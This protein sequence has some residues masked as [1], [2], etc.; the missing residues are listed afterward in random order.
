MAAGTIITV[1]SNI[2]WGQVVDNAPKVADGASKLW[3]AVVNRKKSRADSDSSDGG[4]TTAASSERE[5]LLQRVATLEENV[6]SLQDQMQASTELIKT[7][8]EQNTTLVQRIELNRQKLFR[9]AVAAGV[10]GALLLGLLTYLLV[11]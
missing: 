1:L 6:R 5:V 10:T 8:A 9:L 3:N 2:P 7:L 11:R 4:E